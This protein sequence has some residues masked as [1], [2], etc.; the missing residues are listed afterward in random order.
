MLLHLLDYGVYQI[1]YVWYALWDAYKHCFIIA[2]FSVLVKSYFKIPPTF[3]EVGFF[4]T[5]EYN[6]SN[7]QIIRALS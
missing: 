2:H 1:S 5:Y 7:R 3:F 6:K 4:R